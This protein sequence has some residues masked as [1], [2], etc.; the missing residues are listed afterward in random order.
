MRNINTLSHRLPVLTALILATSTLSG[1]AMFGQ[2]DHI[3]VGSVP[4]DYRTRHPIVIAEK[5]KQLLVP[6]GNAS[7]DLTFAEKEVIS[8][9]LTNYDTQG[10]GAIYVSSPA[11]SQNSGAAGHTANQ[12]ASVVAASGYGGRVIVGQYDAPAD[13]P[14]GPVII[15]YSAI[16]ASAGPCGKWS[17]DVSP[18]SENKNYEN[19]GCAY[20]NNLAAMVAN[21]MDLLGP[22]KIGPI[23]AADR[24]K[25]ISDY[26]TKTGSWSP[27]IRY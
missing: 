16:T 15:S 7:R 6:V 4:D 9:F 17:E 12:I 14:T 24:D 2:R 20:Q 26:R 1:C 27:N 13:Q 8:G 11:N 22:R 23:D 10:S 18:D 19:F 25:V 3:I 21:P 5:Q